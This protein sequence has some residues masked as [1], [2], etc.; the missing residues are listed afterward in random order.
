MDREDHSGVDASFRQSAHLSTGDGQHFTVGEDGSA[1]MKVHQVLQKAV[2]PLLPHYDVTT[3]LHCIDHEM[4]AAVLS[5][6]GQSGERGEGRG[7]G[8]L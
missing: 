8:T 2:M 7:K 4:S 1:A 5:S 3:V 6:D